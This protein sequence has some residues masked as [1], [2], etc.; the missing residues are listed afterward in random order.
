[1]Q[2]LKDFDATLLV[3][4]A[5][6]KAFDVSDPVS[7]QK[8]ALS[9]LR[10]WNQAPA[11]PAKVAAAGIPF[12]LTTKGLKKTNT[13][14]AQLKKAVAYGLSEQAALAALTIRPAKLLGK[15]RELGSLKGLMPTL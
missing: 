4:V 2:A 5:F 3:P 1:M 7:S 8:I 15:Q 9:D 11:N 12:A 6:P 13:F 14:Y 10:Y